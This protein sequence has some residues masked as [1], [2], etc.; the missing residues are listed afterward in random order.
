MADDLVRR[1]PSNPAV[2]PARRIQE[3]NN[4]LAE[5]R[6]LRQQRET[7]AT[8]AMRDVE[9][10]A[11]PP[12]D[13]IEFPSREKWERITKMR[14]KTNMT[15]R[16]KALL[17]AL[18]S[19]VTVNFQGSSLENVINYLQELTGQAVILD[20][21][22]LESAGVKNETPITANFR[23]IALRTL[24]RKILGE[25]QLTY[26][27]KDESLRIVT[28][29]QAQEM[30]TVRTYYLGDLAGVGDFTFGPV[31]A[32]AKMLQTVQQIIQMIVST[33]EPDSWATNNNGGR[34]TIIYDPRTF[35]LV[36]KQSAEV[37][38]ML[39]GLGR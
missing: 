21:D 3:I 35:T 31:F 22:A 19:P 24:L 13:V 28:P 16:E 8:L 38:Y 20:P 30:L 37:H 34:G 1:Y 26:V 12:R 7:G 27:V 15:E 11:I 32:Q 9:H 6:D 14:T 29:K 39:G 33:V 23:G 18:D 2:E 10:S 17:K 4:R 36:V 5:G 25:L